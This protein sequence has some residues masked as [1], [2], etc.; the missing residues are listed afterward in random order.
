[1]FCVLLYF[2]LFVQMY[3]TLFLFILLT[4]L[5]FILLDNM[6]KYISIINYLN[7]LV[8]YL[9]SILLI[10]NNVAA[11][12]PP[13][14]KNHFPLIKICNKGIAHLVANLKKTALNVSIF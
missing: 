10:Y 13:P 12:P 11:A 6:Y 1:M 14:L 4:I 8:F 2:V 7:C 5:L 9:K 3:F